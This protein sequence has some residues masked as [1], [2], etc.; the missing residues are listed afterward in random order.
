MAHAA[1]S[2]FAGSVS[3][4]IFSS[5]AG[6]YQLFD[7]GEILSNVS[8]MARNQGL[9][10]GVR[11][12]NCG[13]TIGTVDKNDGNY[14]QLISLFDFIICTMMPKESSYSQGPE[15]FFKEVTNGI[16][17]VEENM[18]EM[19]K[20]TNIM[21]ETGWASILNGSNGRELNDMKTFWEMMGQWANKEKKLVFMSEAFDNP[22]KMSVKDVHL[23]AHYG[24]WRHL[25][26]EDNSRKAYAR[27][28]L[29][30]NTHNQPRTSAA[31]RNKQSFCGLTTLIFLLGGFVAYS[32]KF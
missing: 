19:R 2:I 26:T 31:A 17:K 11:V 6:F 27:K 9:Q 10:F 29:E 24:L 5:T 21:V 28:V 4:L 8:K 12:W 13:T 15:V 7:M 18:R 14:L 1:N 32:H 30:V 3:G 23:A 20:E 22:W 16:L 25:E